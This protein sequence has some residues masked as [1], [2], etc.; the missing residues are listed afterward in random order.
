ML[1]RLLVN[2]AVSALI[3]LP[4][5]F[6]TVEGAYHVGHLFA[7]VLAIL[8]LIAGFSMVKPDELNPPVFRKVWRAILAVWYAVLMAWSGWVVAAGVWITGCLLAYAQ[9]V[10]AEN[11]AER[12]E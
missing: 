4:L 10:A 6:P 1:T 2:C 3:A 5:M 8:G 9:R 7:W 12:A 11:K